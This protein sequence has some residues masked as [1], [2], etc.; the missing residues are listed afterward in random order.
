MEEYD[1]NLDVASMYMMYDDPETS[2]QAKIIYEKLNKLLPIVQ[3]LSGLGKMANEESY[4]AA[5]D[6]I[7][8]NL[9]PGQKVDISGIQEYYNHEGMPFLYDDQLTNSEEKEQRLE[10]L[11]NYS[12]WEAGSIELGIKALNENLDNISSVMAKDKNKEHYFGQPYA[13]FFLPGLE[14]PEIADELE[15][16][17]EGKGVYSI[18]TK[19]LI[20]GDRTEMQE[21]RIKSNKS[22]GDKYGLSNQDW[23]DYYKGSRDYASDEI[24][25]SFGT[26]IDIDRVIPNNDDLLKLNN[27]LDIYMTQSAHGKNYDNLKIIDKNLEN[28]NTEHSEITERLNNLNNL[29]TYIRKQLE[30]IGD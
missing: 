24:V 30:F 21:N 15:E 13:H 18:V 16:T 7:E 27:E 1:F 8:N 3:K 22:F 11:R 28:Y 19:S 10:S 12:M 9:I 4:N 25:A 5:I 23:E 14:N 17:E 20:S 6:K 29:N 26:D 2:D